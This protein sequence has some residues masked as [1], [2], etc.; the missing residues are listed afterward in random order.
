MRY[1]RLTICCVGFAFALGWGLIC[2][3]PTLAQAQTRPPNI[4][5]ILAD[6]LG[7][8]DLGCYGQKQIRTPHLDRLAAEGLR[9]TQF[10]AGSTVCAPSRCVLMTGLHTG[11]CYIRGNA[12]YDL[13]PEDR[14]LAEILKSAGYATAHIGKWGLGH[15][16]STGMPTRKGFDYFFG[17]LDQVHAHNYYPTFLIR[18]EAHVRL[19]NV[20]PRE[21]K[22]GEGVASIRRHYS[23]DLFTDEALRWITQHRDK[24]FFLYLCYTVPHANNE[25]LNPK[26]VPLVESRPRHG[27]EVP[28]FGIYRD[29]SWPESEKA[30]A[31]MITRLDHDVGRLVARLR[32]LGLDKNTLILFSSD[33]GPHAEGGHDPK[34]FQSSGGLR[35]MKRDLYEGG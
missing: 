4:V 16:S 15:E 14:T 25:A 11:H 34:F 8:G 28:D 29:R 18:N 3:A 9:F 6:D 1:I 26:Y 10:Y 24:P 17:Y 13:R 21:G 33:N 32:E 22:Y 30:F 20:V 23:H 35:G 12:R 27:M 19:E 31:A 7:Y 5:L 2:P